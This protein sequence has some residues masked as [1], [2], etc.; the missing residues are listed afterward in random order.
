M[1]R[2]GYVA[3]FPAIAFATA[4]PAMAKGEAAK[5]KL[6][7][8]QCAVCHKIDKAGGNGIG[9]NLSGIVGRPAGS[10]AGFSYSPALAKLKAPWTVER[11]DAYIAR[12]AAAVPGTRMPFAGI[13]DPAKRQDI[14][15]YLMT[16]SR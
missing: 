8:G 6:A 3:V 15:A 4:S 12:P 11:L 1:K 9:P 13:S 14:I 7:F 5:G 16:M 2:F 10:L